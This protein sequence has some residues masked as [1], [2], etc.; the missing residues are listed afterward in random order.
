MFL[1]LYSPLGQPGVSFFKPPSC[2]LP[3]YNGQIVSIWNRRFHYLWLRSFYS[4]WICKFIAGHINM[5][6]DPAELIHLHLDLD[7]HLDSV[8]CLHYW[9][10]DWSSFQYL[11]STI[12][13]VKILQILKYKTIFSQKSIYSIYKAHIY[14]YTKKNHTHTHNYSIHT[15]NI[16]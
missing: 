3:F 5:C 14:L 8:S 16:N 15:R 12:C 2:N 1:I 11:W 13:I 10:P 6:G 4:C 9:V 7:L